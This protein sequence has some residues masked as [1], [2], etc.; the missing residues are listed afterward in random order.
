MRLSPQQYECVSLV[1]RGLENS[2]IAEVLGLERGTVKRH[3]E[4]ALRKTGARNRV[5]LALM[6]ERRQIAAPMLEAA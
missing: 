3:L 4:M 5:V 1:A 6:F 2:E